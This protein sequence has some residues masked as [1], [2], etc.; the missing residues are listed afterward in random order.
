V[1][2]AELQAALQHGGWS[3]GSTKLELGGSFL[4][5]TDPAGYR[6]TAN[7]SGYRLG[8]SHDCFCN[9]ADTTI[10]EFCSEEGSWES[11]SD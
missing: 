10:Y 11:W 8:F 3:L 2:N 1:S 6:L 4:R 5:G 7:G 9:P